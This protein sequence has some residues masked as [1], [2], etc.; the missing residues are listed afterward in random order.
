MN[1]YFKQNE[2]YNFQT[3]ILDFHQLLSRHVKLSVLCNQFTSVV[4]CNI[5]PLNTIA[6]YLTNILFVK[7]MMK[8]ERKHKKSNC[9]VI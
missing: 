9:R 4:K 3:L 1:E 8:K 2:S 5:F 6:R 7:Y